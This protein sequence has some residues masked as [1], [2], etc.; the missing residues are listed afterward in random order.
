[1]FKLSIATSYTNPE[2]NGPLEEAL[3]CYEDLP[4]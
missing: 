2:K 1:M 4:R 3:A